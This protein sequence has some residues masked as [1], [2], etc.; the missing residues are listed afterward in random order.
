LQIYDRKELPIIQ[1]GKLTKNR[2]I[3]ANV[4]K[5]DALAIPYKAEL[6]KRKQFITKNSFTIQNIIN[7]QKT[8]KE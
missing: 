6:K 7:K 8:C 4:E 3:V 5:G 2:L 1:N